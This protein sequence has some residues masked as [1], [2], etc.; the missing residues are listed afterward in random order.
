MNSIKK[1]WPLITTV[2]LLGYCTNESVQSNIRDANK[3]RIRKE[4]KL[5][6]EKNL[7]EA[8]RINGANYK[9]IKTLHKPKDS[10][11]IYTYEVQREWL[12]ESELPSI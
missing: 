4:V 12:G 5:Q 2:L 1:Y 6:I 3:E 10:Q 7:I 9:W 11:K 8:I